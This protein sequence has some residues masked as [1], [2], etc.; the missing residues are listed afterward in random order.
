MSYSIIAAIGKN[1]E[2]G[3]DNDLIWHLPND[4]RFFK[5]T[6][7]GKTIIMGRRTFES[8]PRML[9]NRH[10]IVLSSSTDFP[11]EVEVYKELKDLL[12]AYKDTNEELFVIG[13]ASIYK[14][15]IDYSDKLYLTE[16]DA[17]CKDAD[18]YFPEFD[19]SLYDKEIIKENSDDNI[20]YKHVLYKR[21][22]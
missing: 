22:K 4:L 8:L 15:F 7:T 18:A 13:G 11:E 17:E 3:K 20:K 1:N 2:L 9:P 10:H 19:K 12:E 6:T 21:K 14:L 5:E 16:I